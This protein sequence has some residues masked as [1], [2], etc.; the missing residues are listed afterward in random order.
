MATKD[1]MLFMAL[2]ALVMNLNVNEYAVERVACGYEKP[3]DK[4]P[5][6]LYLNNLQINLND[7]YSRDDI[8]SF[9][10]D[11][12]ERISTDLDYAGYVCDL[13]V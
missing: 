11:E 9:N 4:I 1:D 3:G 7:G 2:R 12:N 13:L 8:P 10:I 6:D 5:L